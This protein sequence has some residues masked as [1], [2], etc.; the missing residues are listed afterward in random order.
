MLCHLSDEFW[1]LSPVCISTRRIEQAN[2][3]LCLLTPSLPCVNR[4]LGSRELRLT[5]ML[6]RA[7]TRLLLL[8]HRHYCVT[9]IGSRAF[10]IQS[11]NNY[12]GRT[13]WSQ[14]CHHWLHPRPLLTE[15]KPKTHFVLLYPEILFRT[16]VM[17][18][19][20]NMELD[21]KNMRTEK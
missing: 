21:V 3:P 7:L 11:S 19:I 20:C 12:F 4:F 13:T 16:Q 1:D 15:R 9:F 10:A 5:L 6:M 8:L 2:I 14:V 17:Y 18:A